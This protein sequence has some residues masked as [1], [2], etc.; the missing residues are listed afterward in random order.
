MS[1]VVATAVS[2]SATLLVQS[3]AM[4][5]FRAAL[6]ECSLEL[7]QAATADQA[8]SMEL[9]SFSKSEQDF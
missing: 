6:M 8:S 3:T 2:T 9:D 5:V 1:A 4:L 7:A